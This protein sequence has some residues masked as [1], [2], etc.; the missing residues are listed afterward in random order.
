MFEFLFKYPAAAFSKGSLVLL[1]SWPIWIFAATVLAAALALAYPLWRKRQTLRVRPIAVWLL[2]TALVSLLL[3]LLWHPAL[4]VAT[5]R[6]Q[7]N[8]VAVVVDDSKSMAQ[9]EDGSTRLEQ[10]VSG[11]KGSLL[12]DLEKKFQVRLYRAGANLARVD[13]P[14]KLTAS[15]PATRI[16]EALRQVVNESATVPIG[17]V[18]LMSDGG[19]SSGGIDLPTISNIRR[20]RIP[21][22]TVGY[23]RE[24]ADRDLELVNVEMPAR[25]LA[26]S[27]LNAQ[28]VIRQHGYDGRKV[29]VTL[30]DGPKA[31]SSREIVLKP[32]GTD[33][34]ETFSFQA[35]PA[36]QKTLQVKIE[37]L[38]GEENNANNAMQ[39]LLAVDGTKPRILYIEGEPK[40]EYKFIRR[41]IELD[42]GLSLS[43]M[44][45]TTQNKIYR[46]GVGNS[47]ELEQG[48]P[49]KVDELF[50]YQA[51]IVG[52]VEFNY[53][54]PAQQELLR[55][56][57]DRRGGGLLFLA[58]RG[59]L[60]DGGWARSS[61]AELLP[62]TL[63]ERKETFH[64]EPA[65][66]SLTA[67]GRDHILCRLEDDPAR[68]FD[69]WKKLPYLQ[70]YQE[71]G[72][73]KPGAVVLAEMTPSTG[74]N[75]MPLL[76]IQNYGRG[77]TAVFATSG[78][79]RWQM[80]QPVEDMTHEV[81][82]QQMLRWLVS[83][84]GGTVTTSLPKSVF[85][86]DQRIPLRMEV[87]DRNY[88]PTSDADVQA[89]ILG[90]DGVSD[91]VSLRPDPAQMGVYTADYGAIKPGAYV[92][93][94]VATR[95]GEEVGRDSAGF[96]REDGLAEN[97][98]IQQN[99]ELLEKLSSQTGGKYYKPS[100]VG[101]IGNEITYSEAG[102]SVRETYDLWDMPAVFL[103]A[104]MLRGGEWLLRRK[105]GVV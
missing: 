13:S 59:A 75:S 62:L 26:E 58:G 47:T 50:G 43:S 38:G 77:R 89:H 82:W 16:G 88:L 42:E 74:R 105:W 93:E 41:A 64:R 23:G 98:H 101:R 14:D 33:Q 2:Q 45:R 15:S 6:P 60:S 78:S 69:R 71:S 100:E 83:G 4:S 79:W 48:F 3:L 34:T 73:P 63:P 54:T 72:V 76:T 37:A 68:N 35:G 86:D 32:E 25:A 24:K 61:L 52:G 10:A 84:T 12:K 56:F 99:R 81:F 28:V 1:G 102:I 30:N 103:L 46:Q 18:I 31:L 55:Q 36:G 39:R 97:F 80:S 29:R 96:L 66:V 9:R 91:T 11:L 104:L 51:V 85:S 94:T 90:P 67:A 27:K 65:T 5:L 53:F 19:E 87:R 8:V 40:W 21:V 92:V 44:L 70:N 95:A 22:H 57:V 20:Q 7:Q 49:A 17:A